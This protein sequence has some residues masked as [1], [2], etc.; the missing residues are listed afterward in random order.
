MAELMLGGQAIIAPAGLHA[1]TVWGWW[2]QDRLRAA[3]L[4]CRPAQGSDRPF[5]QQ[6]Y[7]C[8]R[9]PDMAFI[10]WPE[11]QKEALVSMQFDAQERGYQAHYPQACWLVI[12]RSGQAVGRLIIEATPPR[13]RV[14]DIALMPEHR[15]Q[16]LGSDLL[17]AMLLGCDQQA[18]ICDLQVEQSNPATHLYRRLGFVDLRRVE[19]YV[20]MQ[21]LPKAAGRS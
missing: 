9:A 8:L 15:S 17:G 21:R 1:D 14:V 4:T 3:G 12:E 11:A 20:V 6:L 13:L 16:G 19:P 5:F 18:W 7:R 2:S 10:P